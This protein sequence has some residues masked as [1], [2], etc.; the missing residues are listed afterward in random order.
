LNGRSETGG[1]LIRNLRNPN[2]LDLLKKAKYGRCGILLQAFG[3]V[4]QAIGSW[5]K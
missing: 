4:L 5:P 3:F 2:V 1:F